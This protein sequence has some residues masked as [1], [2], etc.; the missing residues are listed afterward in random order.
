MPVAFAQVREDPRLDLAMVAPG[1]RVLM[2]AS[3][4]ETAMCL[5]RLPLERLMVVDVN[6]AQLALV[7]CKEWLA[8]NATRQEA[9]EWL[10]HA[11]AAREERIAA[12]LAALG[13]ERDALGPLARVA[14]LG[15]DGAGR[16]ELLFAA[17]RRAGEPS[18]ETFEQVMSLENLVTLFGTGATQNPRQPFA[19]H[20]WERTRDAL[21][22]S[23]ANPFLWQVLEGRFPP[24]FAWDWLDDW[25]VPQVRLEYVCAP[26]L[27]ALA[28]FEEFD[29]VHLSNILD[30]LSPEEATRTLRAASQALRPGGKVSVRQLNSTLDIPALG[31][32]RWS[33]VHEPDRSYFYRA[34]YVG[35]K[36]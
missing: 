24:G 31:E 28:G 34:L 19:R 12:T 16:Y 18:L 35:T 15:P 20:F 23:T 4:G 17:L 6:P 21:R 30:W 11:P 7:R 1:E 3:G 32:F 27:E 10:G 9:L 8:Y 5:A 26:M 33:Q 22:G 36:P 25:R 13:L 29:L 2:V 14:E